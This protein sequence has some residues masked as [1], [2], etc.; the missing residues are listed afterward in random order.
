MNN[1]LILS[2][3]HLSVSFKVRHRELKA[4]RDISLELKEKETLAI[5]GES[6]SGKSVLTKTF[7]GMLEQNGFITNGTIYYKGQPLNELKKEF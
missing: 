2:V 1:E 3:E 5:V 6:G 4:I 7:T